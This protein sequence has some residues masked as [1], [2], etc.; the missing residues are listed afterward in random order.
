[1]PLCVEASNG[2]I[3]FDDLMDENSS[4]RKALAENVA[5]QR[6]PSLGTRPGVYYIL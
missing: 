4:V 5:V 1:M 2:G 6:K 3:L